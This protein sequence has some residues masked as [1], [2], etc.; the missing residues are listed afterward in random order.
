MGPDEAVSVTEQSM[1]VPDLST[2]I[3]HN[4]TYLVPD[5]ARRTGS[6]FGADALGDGKH[7]QVLH[8]FELEIHGRDFVM[9]EWSRVGSHRNDS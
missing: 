3:H 7:R 6:S 9:S 4:E 2:E 8:I 1:A 5:E